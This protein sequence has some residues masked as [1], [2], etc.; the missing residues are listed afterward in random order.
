MKAEII[1][2]R[3]INLDTMKLIKRSLERSYGVENVYVIGNRNGTITIVCR[4]IHTIYVS[5]DGR[6]AITFDLDDP[7]V[8]D[9]LQFL[10]KLVLCYN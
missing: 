8:Y 5:D 4:S 6:I 1:L 2:P 3:K 9:V 7:Y 10:K